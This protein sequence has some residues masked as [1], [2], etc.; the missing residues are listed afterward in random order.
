[1]AFGCFWWDGE[2]RR[3]GLLVPAG[4]ADGMAEAISALLRDEEVR[5]HMSRSAADAGRRCVDLK[6]QVE[7]YLK[8]YEEILEVR[9]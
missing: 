3:T 9:R 2:E 4:D 6:Q 8:W 5:M 1:L 7:K